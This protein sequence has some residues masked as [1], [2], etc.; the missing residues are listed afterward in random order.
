MK[1]EEREII[2]WE[3]RAYMRLLN[4]LELEMQRKTT[5]HNL[6]VI[7]CEHNVSTEV[8]SMLIQRGC[9]IGISDD[10]QL[11]KQGSEQ[12]FSEFNFFF[13]KELT[14]ELADMLRLWAVYQRHIR[15]YL[16]REQFITL[17]EVSAEGHSTR[18][19]CK[20]C[21]EPFARHRKDQIY[22]GD[23]CRTYA[24]RLRTSR[25]KLLIRFALKK[26]TLWERFLQW[27]QSLRRK[28]NYKLAA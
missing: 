5:I 19:S 9:I 3:I 25:E 28:S 2:K 17:S 16:K 18:P 4:G 6:K 11:Y 13:V 22:C 26:R 7:V 21:Q 15:N 10:N 23:T 20:H 12:D 14:Y 24:S 8:L 27:V 1:P